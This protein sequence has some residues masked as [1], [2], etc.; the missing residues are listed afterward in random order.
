LLSDIVQEAPAVYADL[1]ATTVEAGK[2][3][4][5]SG[6][7][8]VGDGG[9][10]FFDGVTGAAAGTYVDNGGTILV[11]GGSS[12]AWLRFIEGDVSVKW[13]GRQAPA[14]P[15]RRDPSSY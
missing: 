13:F 4:Y 9:E 3:Y 8:L 2:S 10:G 7:S 1:Q 12:S 15:T 5:L 11:P 14:I 6:R